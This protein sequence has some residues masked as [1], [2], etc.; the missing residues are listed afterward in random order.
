M[1]IDE[2]TPIEI[3][4]NRMKESPIETI[5]LTIILI[6]FLIFYY[7]LEDTPIMQN[8]QKRIDNFKQRMIVSLIVKNGEIQNTN[9]LS[10]SN[11]ALY[12]L[13]FFGMV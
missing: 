5:I 4:K 7:F 6:M 12:L 3:I 11:M 2:N 9:S 13:E 8:I 10:F 1:K